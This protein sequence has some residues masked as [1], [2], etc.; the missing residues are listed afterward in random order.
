[1]ADARSA[2]RRHAETSAVLKRRARRARLSGLRAMPRTAG[3]VRQEGLAA[4]SQARLGYALAK[5]EALREAADTWVEAAKR[6]ARNGD[7]SAG[8]QLVNAAF[9]YR[10]VGRPDD[11]LAAAARALQIRQVPQVPATRPPICASRTCWCSAKRSR[12]RWNSGR[13]AHHPVRSKAPRRTRGPGRQHRSP[14]RRPRARTPDPL[15]A[16]RRA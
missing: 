15:D 6:F 16:R 11:A 1:M 3:V 10:D 8:R 2:T 4:A 12:R 5:T 13:A 7:P 14:H 9:A